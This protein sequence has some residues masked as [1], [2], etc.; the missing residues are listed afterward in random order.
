MT[1]EPSTP[2][3]RSPG[4]ATLALFAA[5]VVLGSSNFIAVRYSNVEL[6][7]F[8]GAGLRFSLAGFAF[9]I[10]AWLTR[11]VWPR[12]RV[13]GLMVA[14][15]LVTF[16][17]SYALLYWALV[18]VTAGVSAVVLALVPLL[19]VLLAALQRLEPLSRRTVVGGLVALL[20]IVWMT[21]GA[22]GLNAP[23][24][25]VL[26]VLAASVSVAQSVILGKKLSGNSPVMINAVGMAAGA[27][28][29]FALSAIVG[30]T[31]AMP[32][33]AATVTALLYLVVVGSLGLFVAILLMIR[34]WTASASAYTFVMFPVTTMLLEAWLLEVP[35]TSR[36][37]MGAAVVMAGVWIGAFARRPAMSNLPG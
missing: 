12:G 18:T 15:G 10:I 32:R 26:A 31:W 29:L 21:G 3:G 30:E 34:R 6:D 8:W 33:Q 9:V 20:G 35:L 37:L 7:P 22:G 17:L 25:G 36:G 27:P 16:T 19:T 14:Y 2:A 11:S 1:S 13:L 28:P 24:A 4:A 5:V 23:L